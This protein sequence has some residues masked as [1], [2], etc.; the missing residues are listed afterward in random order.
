MT[1]HNL[2]KHA[3]VYAPN[4]VPSPA[5]WRDPRTNE[6]L[7][8]IKLNMNDFDSAVVVEEPIV[9]QAEEVVESEPAKQTKTKNSK[10]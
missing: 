8:A 1:K 6:L 5:G 7:V 9:E 2:Y 10:K 3:P 4:A